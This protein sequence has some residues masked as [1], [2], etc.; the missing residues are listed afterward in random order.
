M[1]RSLLFTFVLFL[2]L[3]SACKFGSTQQVQNTVPSPVPSI[4]AT[5][6]PVSPAETGVEEAAGRSATLKCLET[7]TDNFR[8]YRKQTFAFD[9]EPFKQSCFVTSF[10]P[11]YGDNPPL[12]SNFAIYKDGKKAFDFP[13]QFNGVTSG[14]WVEAVAFQDLNEDRLTDIIVVGKCSAKS[15]PYNENMVYVNTGK[16][17]TTREDANFQLTDKTTIKAIADF[18]KEN[19]TMFFN[20]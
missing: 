20:N 11:E 18:V 5:P 9:F 17:F 10:D 14:C 16:T 13:S 8:V 12:E 7:M 2:P 3:V 4:S 19:R 15:A 1:I 6:T